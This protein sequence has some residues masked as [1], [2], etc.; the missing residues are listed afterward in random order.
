ML[1]NHPGQSWWDKNNEGADNAT[2][3]DD[4]RSIWLRD[5]DLAFVTARVL[6]LPP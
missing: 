6:G 5:Q 4:F 1:T 2:A 3:N